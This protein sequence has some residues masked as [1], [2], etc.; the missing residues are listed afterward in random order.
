M[1]ESFST[2]ATSRISRSLFQTHNTKL[3]QRHDSLIGYIF[4]WEFHTLNIRS[5]PDIRGDA[6]TVECKVIQ[7][8][9]RHFT[10]ASLDTLNLHRLRNF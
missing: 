2:S 9:A 10:D 6:R 3:Y 7:R 1:Y 4:M 8:R 5:S